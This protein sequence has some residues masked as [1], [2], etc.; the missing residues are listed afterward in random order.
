MNDLCP[1]AA[2]GVKA[3]IGVTAYSSLPDGSA[4]V[5]ASAP[6]SGPGSPLLSALLS[7]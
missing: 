7:T 1:A 4:A 2:R 3:K 6:A 5:A